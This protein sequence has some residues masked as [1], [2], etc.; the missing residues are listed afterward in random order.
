MKKK[1]KPRKK[2]KDLFEQVGMTMNAYS[3]TVT[4]LG[5]ICCASGDEGTRKRAKTALLALRKLKRK[6]KGY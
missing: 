4:L 3:T 5:L 6:V 1:T 2:R